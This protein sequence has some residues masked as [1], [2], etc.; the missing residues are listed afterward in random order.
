MEVFLGTL[1]RAEKGNESPSIQWAEPGGTGGHGEVAGMPL[2]GG[3]QEE[4]EGEEGL[5]S[6]QSPLE[7]LEAKRVGT[8][9]KAAM[10]H[11]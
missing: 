6:P 10:S 3:G 11:L 8:V 1:R 9:T 2:R 5:Q 7:C 4:E